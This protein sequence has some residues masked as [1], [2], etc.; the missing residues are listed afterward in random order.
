MDLDGFLQQETTPGLLLHGRLIANAGTKAA[1]VG[2]THF[3]KRVK[4]AS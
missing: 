3:R 4:K 2:T 1:G